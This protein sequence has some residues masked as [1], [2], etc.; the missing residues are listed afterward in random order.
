[1]ILMRKII[2][3]DNKKGLAILEYA[4]LAGVFILAAA[5]MQV[6]V[7]R[8]MQGRIKNNTDSVGPQY[9]AANSNYNYH[10]ITY[11]LRSETADTAGE[12]R[13]ELLDNEVS[14]KTSYTDD[15]SGRPLAGNN[16][17]KLLE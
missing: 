4:V 2:G 1:M 6:Y 14:G 16:A 5:G 3:T 10:Q 9:S 7:L 13:S 15:F 12:A 8:A 17:E 11:S